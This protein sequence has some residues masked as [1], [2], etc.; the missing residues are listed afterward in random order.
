MQAAYRNNHQQVDDGN[1]GSKRFVLL[2]DQR[3]LKGCFWL[4]GAAE[5][6]REALYC[7]HNS[8]RLLPQALTAMLGQRRMEAQ[9][10]TT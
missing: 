7:F 5:A 10:A 3:P 6:K 9:R 4:L 1:L 2:P 8:R